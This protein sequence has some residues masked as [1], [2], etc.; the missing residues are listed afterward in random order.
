MILQGRANSLLLVKC[1]GESAM[2]R[3]SPFIITSS[4]HGTII[5]NRKD[6]AENAAGT[7]GVGHEILETQSFQA[8]EIQLLKDLLVARRQAYG[9]GLVV[10]DCGANIGVHT[11]DC[12]R[13]MTGWGSI[14]A[15]EPQERIYYALAGNIA[16]NNLF[17]ARATFAAVG[18]TDGWITVPHLDYN[19]P[20]SFGSLEIRQRQKTEKIGQRISY[21]EK[22]GQRVP[23]VRIDS[24]ERDRIDLIK[25][26]VEGME[27]EA[28]AGAS[29]TLRR[30]KP[31]I[32]VEHI[33]CDRERL[34]EPLIGAGY[35]CFP[36]G[37][38]TMAIHK[39]DKVKVSKNN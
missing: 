10:L 17:N 34:S 8:E 30:H 12:A 14:E 38:N 29:E 23:M 6:F 13:L 19:Q 26:D 7:F 15:F 37:M 36:A 32:F 20:A 4:D 28:L 31:I 2:K 11:L 25:L 24:L 35:N 18:E 3:P 16:I 5:V 27:V 22:D 21:D 33:K 9:D 39:D 1:V